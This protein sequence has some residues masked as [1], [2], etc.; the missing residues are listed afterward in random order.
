M[1]ETAFYIFSNIWACLTELMSS[2]PGSKG[3]GLFIKVVMDREI[4]NA[5]NCSILPTSFIPKNVRENYL[6]FL[7]WLCI[8]NRCNHTLHLDYIY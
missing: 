8:I 3:T 4:N 7:Y 1:R 5:R 6:N 2:F